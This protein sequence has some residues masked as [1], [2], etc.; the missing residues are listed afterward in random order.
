MVLEPHIQQLTHFLIITKV[1]FP[2]I[3]KVE[4]TGARQ[5]EH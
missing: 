5:K 2:R 3:G 1:S 4:P